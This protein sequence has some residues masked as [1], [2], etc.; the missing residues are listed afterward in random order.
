VNEEQTEGISYPHVAGLWYRLKAD[1]LVDF[2]NPQPVERHTNAF[3]L[4][5]EETVLTVWM[6][7]HHATEN[8]A[9]ERVERYLRSWEISAAL[10][11]HLKD[12]ESSLS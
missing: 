4:R 9:R 12:Q 3:Y 6:K 10:Q 2:S 5:L 11:P 7:E 8:S 1:E